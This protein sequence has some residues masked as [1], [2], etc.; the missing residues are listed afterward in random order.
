MPYVLQ[1]AAYA[2][3][4]LVQAPDFNLLLLFILCP[5]ASLRCGLPRLVRPLNSQSATVHSHPV[6]WSAPQELLGV[7]AGPGL[8]TAPL[9]F[10]IYN[11]YMRHVNR[12]QG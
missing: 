4:S 8:C 3:A 1:S 7:S 10:A 12:A 2:G 6:F 5:A 11:N 9:E